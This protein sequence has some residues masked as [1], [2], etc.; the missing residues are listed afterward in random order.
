M[1]DLRSFR[2]T[3]LPKNFPTPFLIPSLVPQVRSLLPCSFTY[4]YR[5]FFEHW[6]FWLFIFRC[7]SI[8]LCNDSYSRLRIPQQ[9]QTH[10]T[11]QGK[12]FSSDHFSFLSK[13]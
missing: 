5:R 2:I 11:L 12:P 1:E 7:N 8:D 10:S 3:Q 9:R 13:R 4:L 6:L